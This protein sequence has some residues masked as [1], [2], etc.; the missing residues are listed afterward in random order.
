MD[1]FDESDGGVP[2]EI[3]ANI[4]YET[5]DIPGECP[6]REDGIKG[7]ESEGETLCA[8]ITDAVGNT[9]PEPDFCEV[10]VTEYECKETTTRKLSGRRLETTY[11]I[12]AV[13]ELVITT[14]KQPPVNN[15]HTNRH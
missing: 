8:N 11:A 7:I 12:T 5:E 13:L 2:N 10:E 4:I 14:K 3:E 9:D 6:S 1:P 15:E